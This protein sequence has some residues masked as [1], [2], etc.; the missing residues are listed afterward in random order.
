MHVV[1]HGETLHL[2][3]RRNRTS[4]NVLLRL[5]PKLRRRPNLIYAGESIR[6]R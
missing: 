6:V 5:N 4:V 2:I 1:R 3:A